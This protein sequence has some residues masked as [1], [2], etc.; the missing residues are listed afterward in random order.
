[1][2]V[3]VN[4]R[5]YADAKEGHTYEEV[6]QR[7]CPTDVEDRIGE[8]IVGYFMHSPK[9]RYPARPAWYKPSTRKQIKE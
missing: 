3:A 9:N 4:L 1:M 8:E 7:K 6:E 5:T 2:P